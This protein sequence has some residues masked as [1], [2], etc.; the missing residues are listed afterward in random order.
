M[1]AAGGDNRTGVLTL[2]REY[3]CP[4]TLPAQPSWQTPGPQLMLSVP[5]SHM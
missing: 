2:E 1:S 5:E 4:R 3:P